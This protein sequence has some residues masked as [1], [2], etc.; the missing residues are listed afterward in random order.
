MV[1]RPG[2]KFTKPV[3]WVAPWKLL[4]FNHRVAID[5]KH[6]AVVAGGG[7]VDGYRGGAGAR[8]HDIAIPAGLDVVIDA[9]AEIV[10]SRVAHAIGEPI[11]RDIREVDGPDELRGHGGGLIPQPGGIAGVSGLDQVLG[12]GKVE[13]GA[14]EPLDQGESRG[15]SAADDTG[16]RVLT[17]TGIGEVARR[18]QVDIAG[19]VDGASASQSDAP[20]PLANEI[21]GDGGGAG[22]GDRQSAIAGVGDGAADALR[23]FVGS[24]RLMVGLPPPESAVMV[25]GTASEMIRIVSVLSEVSRVMADTSAAGMVTV[26]VPAPVTNPAPAPVT[27]MVTAGSVSV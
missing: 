7:E 6:A 27:A 1:C 14:D 3:A 10:I 15:G 11:V 25:M 20:A 13:I 26:E 16:D 18:A 21:A 5:I 9:G 8:D 19:D 23:S 4:L 17:G 22:A 2:V 24:P 12:R